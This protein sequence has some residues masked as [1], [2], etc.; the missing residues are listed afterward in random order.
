MSCKLQFVKSDRG[1][2]YGQI[3]KYAG[4]FGGVQVLNLLAALIRN[5]LVALLLG[6]VGLGLI[7][8]YNTAVKLLNEATNLGVSFTAVRQISEQTETGG[9]AA[10]RRTVQTVRFWSLLTAAVG[11][12]ACCG[13]S[14]VLSRLYF[15]SADGWLDFIWLSPVVALTALTG[16][17]LAVL[18]GARRLNQVAVY[19]I[20]NAFL[21]LAVT[22]PF[23]YFLGIAGILPALSAAA[24]AGAL[25]V[26]YFSVRAFPYNFSFPVRDSLREGSGMLRLG[27]A[28]VC[29]GILGS[30]VEFA[31]RAYIA[32]A[33]SIADVGLYNA[34]YMLTVTYASVIFMSMETDFFPRLSAVNKN[35]EQSNLTVNRQIEVSVLL[36]CP[37]LAFFL[38]LLPVALPLLFSSKFLPVMEM[39][40]FGVLAMAFRAVMLPMEYM[41]LAKGRSWVYLFTEGLYD[42]AAVGCIIFGYYLDGL[43][44]SGAGLLAASAFNLVLVW[45]VCTRCYGFAISGSA[46]R[47]IALQ[48]PLLG[49][50]YLS[51]TFCSGWTYWMTAILC[52]SVSAAVSL[53]SL[54]RKT[55]FLSRLIR[56]KNE[57]IDSDSRL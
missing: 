54:H 30:G 43:R 33:G 51:V 34:G 13:L 35:R 15:G 24:L 25:S 42:L 37:L 11:A 18:K 47:K 38:V 52:A 10:A 56:R 55:G 41:S 3:I 45:T 9:E 6:P 16:G 44:G 53:V 4:F 2:T 31:V 49:A 17:E 32:S 40:Q 50:V 14:P 27:V 48:L 5:K 1:N 8:L 22:L 21:S 57:N 28:F 12:V 36:L 20:A 7:S 19:S 46:V 29:A 23:F 26:L 39:A